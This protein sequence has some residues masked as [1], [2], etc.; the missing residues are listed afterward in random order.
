[1]HRI[2]LLAIRR[3]S[4]QLKQCSVRYSMKIDSFAF[5]PLTSFR[6]PK[7][8]HTTHSCAHFNIYHWVYAYV[9]TIIN[10]GSVNMGWNRIHFLLFLVYV[11]SIAHI[12]QSGRSR[13]VRPRDAIAQW[14]SKW[15]YCFVSSFSDKHILN[16][17]LHDAEFYQHHPQ[18][19]CRRACTGIRFRSF[20]F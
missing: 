19:S 9:I 8:S 2:S 7:R 17:A 13:M 6:L 1:M 5:C 3:R 12:N 4:I 16:Q 10:H 11:Q 15:Q 18:V 20:H 14:H